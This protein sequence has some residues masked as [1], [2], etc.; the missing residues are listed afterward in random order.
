MNKPTPQIDAVDHARGPADARV[1]VIEYGDFEC[2]ACGQAYAAVE[3]ML[4]KFAGLVRFA[5]RH[6]PLTEVHPHAE[7]AAE[8][9]EAA[10]AQGKFWEMHAALFAHQ[11]H[12]KENN[13]R[14]YAQDLELDLERYDYEMKDQVY[15]QR[16]REHL[17]SGK[18][19]ECGQPPRFLST[20]A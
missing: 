9:A 5:F 18:Q 17:A 11:R 1:G 8:A 10:G 4:K 6:Y 14:Q 13:L 7:H 20:A 12:L 2:P 16:L 19:R 3:I 15:L